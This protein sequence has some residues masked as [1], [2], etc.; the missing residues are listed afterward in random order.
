VRGRGRASVDPFRRRPYATLRNRN[1]WAHRTGQTQRN[2]QVTDD[3]TGRTVDRS[4]PPEQ[5]VT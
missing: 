1:V 4:A 5:P 3:R 2:A